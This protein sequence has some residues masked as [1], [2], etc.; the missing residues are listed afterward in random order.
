[1][2]QSDNYGFNEW[3]SVLTFGTSFFALFSRACHLF[4]GYM[5]SLH[6]PK[7]VFLPGLST[8]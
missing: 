8:G 7:I 4:Q 3:Q 2:I 1:M 5:F 6:L